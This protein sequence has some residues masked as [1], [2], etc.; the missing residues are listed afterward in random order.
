MDR[1]TLRAFQDEIDTQCKLVLIG[2][3]QLRWALRV[4]PQFDRDETAYVWYAIQGILVSSA[5]ISKCCWGAPREGRQARKRV[6]KERTPLRRFLRVTEESALRNR[7]VRN[8]FEHIDEP[9]AALRFRDRY[10]GRNVGPPTAFPRSK[11]PRFAHFNPASGWITIAG[12]RVKLD[13]LLREVA[14]V[15]G[16]ARVEPTR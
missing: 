13:P 15:Y 9:L 12:D 11:T 1:M 4:V 2:A 7:A 10:V 3:E 16:I 14:R 8:A 5:N 6:E